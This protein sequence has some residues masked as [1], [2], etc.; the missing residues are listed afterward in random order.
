M[1]VHPTAVVS[2]EAIISPKAE[3][4]PFCVISGKAQIGAYTTL[5]SNVRVGNPRGE[6][7]IGEHNHLQAGAALGGPPQDLAHDDSPSKLVVGDHNR[8]GECATVSL[9]SSTGSGVTQV[10]NHCFL[11]AYAHVGH[12]C[13]IGDEV[14]ITNLAQLAGHV[15]V[16]RKVVVSG[17]VGC[18]QF[19]RLGEL[20][21]LTA[22]TLVNKDVAPYSIADGR[23]AS[24]RAVNR[25]G[26]QRAGLD[27]REIRNIG[28]AMRILM[29][30]SFTIEEVTK[31][32][33]GECL[34]S[35]NIDHLTNFVRTSEKGILRG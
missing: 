33:V 23:W 20:S 17:M 16:E 27:A 19:V 29:N 10:G 25:V 9:G 28:C 13:L 35:P 12:D 30:N 24:L 11:M 22:G 5:D 14:V 15:T 18:T 32:I 21:F 3:I 34:P 2:K 26:L 8:F 7:I 1:S 4:G 31:K 6:V